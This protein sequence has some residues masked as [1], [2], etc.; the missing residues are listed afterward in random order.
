M[1]CQVAMQH[2]WVYCKVF[3][4]A[5]SDKT[6]NSNGFREF[7]LEFSVF[8]KCFS[9][10]SYK[11]Y[12]FFGFCRLWIFVYSIWAVFF[13]FFLSFLDFVFCTLHLNYGGLK[14]VGVY[15]IACLLFGNS[16]YFNWNLSTNVYKV[17]FCLSVGF[18]SYKKL[19]ILFFYYE[20]KNV[21]KI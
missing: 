15:V 12:S 19:V 16:L 14:L 8:G 21:L 2:I 10:F 6:G 18:F 1:C 9:F 20:S 4:S 17:R 5:K 13:F 3:S 11:F 7:Y